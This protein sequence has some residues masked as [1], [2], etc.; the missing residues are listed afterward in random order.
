MRCCSPCGLASQGPEQGTCFLNLPSP[1]SHCVPGGWSLHEFPQQ[2]PFPSYSSWLQIAKHSIRRLQ[3]RKG[4]LFNSLTFPLC[5]VSRAGGLLD[6]RSKWLLCLAL[7]PEEPLLTASGLKDYDL[8]LFLNNLWY[9]SITCGF[10]TSHPHFAK[11]PC[12]NYPSNEP[13]WT[14][15]LSLIS[16]LTVLRIE[17]GST[18][19]TV[20]TGKWRLVSLSGLPDPAPNGSK[21]DPDDFGFHLKEESGV[22]LIQINTGVPIRPWQLSSPGEGLIHE[23]FRATVGIF[24]FFYLMNIFFSTFSLEKRGHITSNSLNNY[25]SIIRA[26]FFSLLWKSPWGIRARS[27]ESMSLLGYWS[28]LQSFWFEALYL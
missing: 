25:F 11:S 17:N 20:W 21:H 5:D 4:K 7:S 24:F 18:V 27:G 26:H 22:L 13:I 8:L 2:A 3:E 15:L 12:I 10:S 14:F 19:R 23:K 28:R 6:Q 16:Y 1:L 9:Y